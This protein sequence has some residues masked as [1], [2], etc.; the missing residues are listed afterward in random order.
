MIEKNYGKGI[1]LDYGKG[2]SLVMRARAYRPSESMRVPEAFTRSPD[3]IS[4]MCGSKAGVASSQ[5]L[6]GLFESV[7]W[8]TRERVEESEKSV[9]SSNPVFDLLDPPVSFATKA[10]VDEGAVER[11][12]DPLIN[13]LYERYCDTLASPFAQTSLNWADTVEG[14]SEPASSMDS[15]ADSSNASVTSILGDIDTIEQA[16]GQFE[17]S[18]LLDVK[19]AVPEVLSLFAPSELRAV[20]VRPAEGVPPELVRREHHTLSL[21]SPM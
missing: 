13:S 8:E 18:G 7:S 19:E 16:F 14:R 11:G 3:P 20:R 10:S 9:K 17:K 12:D 15:R 1:Y 21:D 2:V 4:E 6:R 5:D